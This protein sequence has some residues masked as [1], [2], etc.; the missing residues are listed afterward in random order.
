MQHT[1]TNLDTLLAEIFPKPSNQIVAGRFQTDAAN[2][3]GE[4]HD[5]TCDDGITC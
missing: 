4:C 1:Q 3:S 2:C 5:G